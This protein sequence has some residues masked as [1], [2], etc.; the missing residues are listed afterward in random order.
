MCAVVVGLCEVP[1]VAARQRESNAKFRCFFPTDRDWYWVFRLCSIR[2]QFRRNAEVQLFSFATRWQRWTTFFFKWRE[3]EV[4]KWNSWQSIFWSGG[5]DPSAGHRV[6]ATRANNIRAS[7]VALAGL[8]NLFE[9]SLGCHQ[10]NAAVTR[11]FPKN[12]FRWTWKRR[13]ATIWLG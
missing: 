9:H 11:I 12:H 1:R 13:V 8:S 6:S 4:W 5:G 10:C 3:F 2:F 7:H